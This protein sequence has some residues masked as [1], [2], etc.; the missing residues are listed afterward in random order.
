MGR[1]RVHLMD[2]RDL[3]SEFAH[4]FDAF[5]SIEMLEHVGSKVRPFAPP[6]I[7]RAAD[8]LTV[9]QAILRVGGFCPEACRRYRGDYLVDVPRGSV[10][11]IPVC[12][13]PPFENTQWRITLTHRLYRADDFMRRYM[14][15]NSC[16]PS[17]TVL[18]DSAYASSGG[19]FTLEA[20]E[21]HAPRTYSPPAR[22][23]P[24]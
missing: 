22:P 8:S 2:Y 18:I 16:L 7:H 24:F 10:Y 5:V 23:N 11:R 13:P 14:W 19:R 4:Q 3:P 6:R 9:L 21:N 12:L 17:A 15:P 20:V 1:V